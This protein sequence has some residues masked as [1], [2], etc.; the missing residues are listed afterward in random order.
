M[1][2]K[3]GERGQKKSRAK[4]GRTREEEAKRKKDGR[5]KKSSRGMGDLG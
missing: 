4:V 2:K 1:G 5:S 3:K